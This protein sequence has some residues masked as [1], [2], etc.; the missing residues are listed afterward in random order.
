[1]FGTFFNTNTIL[2]VRMSLYIMSVT[3]IVIPQWPISEKHKDSYC[4]VSK[5]NDMTDLATLKFLLFIK[6]F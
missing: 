5:W 2:A 6:K 4:A 1:M 3:L